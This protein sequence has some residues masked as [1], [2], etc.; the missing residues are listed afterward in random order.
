MIKAVEFDYLKKIK[1][2]A[3]DFS[4]DTESSSNISYS[5]HNDNSD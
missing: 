4:S 5:S 1:E 2:K 3:S